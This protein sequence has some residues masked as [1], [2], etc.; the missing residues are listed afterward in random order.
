MLRMV[1]KVNGERGDEI[2]Y[3]LWP[4]PECQV[5]SLVLGL[6]GDELL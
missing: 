1:W 5:D 3:S 2:G 4:L 6:W